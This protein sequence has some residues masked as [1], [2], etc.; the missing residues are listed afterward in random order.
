MSQNLVINPGF[1][2]WESET[3][4]SGWSVAMNCLKILLLL[5]QDYIP[6]S[7]AEEPL[8]EVILDRHLHV[9]PGKY[10]YSFVLQ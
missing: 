4:P 2:S 6:V 7:T 10:L 1:E 3:Q 8:P 5:I 9:T